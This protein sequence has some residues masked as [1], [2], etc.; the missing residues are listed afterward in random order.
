[1]LG[2][3]KMTEPTHL[4]CVRCHDE[5]EVEYRHPRRLRRALRAYFFMPLLLVPAF[6]I[7]AS[8]YFV[9]LPMC[10]LYM[11]GIGPALVIV[12]DPPVCARCGALL[13]PRR[14]PA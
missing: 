4:H 13:D 12:R 9:A 6:P 11:L 10:M 14:I 3:L 8:D 7:L 5:V 1:M 2:W